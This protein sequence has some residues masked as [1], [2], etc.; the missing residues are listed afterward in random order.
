MKRKLSKTTATIF[1]VVFGVYFYTAS[2]AWSQEHPAEHPKEHPK[3]HPAMTVAKAVAVLNPT[4]GNTAKGV[5]TFTQEPG[6]VHVV[7]KFTGV[8]K[9][10]HGFHI[11]EFGDCSAPDGT[12]AGSHFNPTNMSHAGRDA[13]KRHMGDMGNV[14]ADEQGN[15][16]LD[17]VDKY[18]VLASLLGRGMILHANP[19]DMTTQPTG[20]AGGRIACG[21]IGVGK[22]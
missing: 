14:T 5:V 7:A 22:P 9:G 1:A 21:V 20:N 19:D 13:E 8:P 4:Q 3:E 10:V 15:V 18:L 17:Y 12:S 2:A 16:T 6:G 11:H